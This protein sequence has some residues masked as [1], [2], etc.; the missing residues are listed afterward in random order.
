M[1]SNTNIKMS[2]T[3]ERERT[4]ERTNEKE[5]K[6]KMICLNTNLALT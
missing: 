6:E 5:K 4:N 2:R 3:N 1:K